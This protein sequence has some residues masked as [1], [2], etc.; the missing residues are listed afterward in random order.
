MVDFSRFAFID[1]ESIPSRPKRSLVSDEKLESSGNKAKRATKGIMTPVVLPDGSNQTQDVVKYGL[2]ELYRSPGCKEMPLK[3]IIIGHNPSGQSWTKGHYYANPSNRMWHLLRVSDI[4]P[5]TFTAVDDQR[6]PNELGVGFTDIMSGISGTHSCTFSDLTVQSHRYSLFRR[7]EAHVQRAHSATGVPQELC[8]PRV[9]AFAG[10]RQWKALFPASHFKNTRDAKQ[11]SIL[12]HLS[13]SAS[14][15]IVGSASR[16][17][18]SIG[19]GDDSG[20]GDL[21]EPG[22]IEAAG[23]GN[24]GYGLQTDRPPGW[25]ECLQSSAVFLLPSS[26]GAAALTNAQREGPYRD[27]G[28]LLQG[29]SNLAWQEG[30]GLAALRRYSAHD[31]T[32]QQA[33]CESDESADCG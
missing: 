2:H 15:A 3:L 7:L 19:D 32:A 8:Y 10:V 29:D 21:K 12:Q 13:V 4:V 11:P 5:N 22:T 31:E 16:T 1:S 30:T 20:T 24:A 27:L 23:G 33:P 9:V 14:D 6:C 26:S 25:P 18:D 17:T 28:L